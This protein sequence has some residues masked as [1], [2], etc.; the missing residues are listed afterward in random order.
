MTTWIIKKLTRLILN[1]VLNFMFVCNLEKI[2]VWT[3]C[4]IVQNVH[5][6]MLSPDHVFEQLLVVYCFVVCVDWNML[7]LGVF[8]WLIMDNGMNVWWLEFPFFIWC[9]KILLEDAYG[10]YGLLMMLVF[11]WWCKMLCMRG[12][13]NILT[14]FTCIMELGAQ[15]DLNVEIGG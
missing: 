13:C 4:V 14:S 8:G 6:F 2:T 11:L 7:I 3:F 10:D 15:E 1:M 5:L 12:S 9:L